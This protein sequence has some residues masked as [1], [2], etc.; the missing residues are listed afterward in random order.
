VPERAVAAL[1]RCE[2]SFTL[3]LLTGREV[4]GLAAG[5]GAAGRGYG[6]SL[7]RAGVYP[8]LITVPGWRVAVAAG[9]RDPG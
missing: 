9:H 6:K 2:P 7:R 1:V 8:V 4:P 3:I 5:P